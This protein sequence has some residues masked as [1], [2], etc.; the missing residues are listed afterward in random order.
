MSAQKAGVDAIAFS[1]TMVAGI[2]GW[3]TWDMAYGG[4]LLYRKTRPF[5]I[6]LILGTCIGIG[7]AS[8]VYSFYYI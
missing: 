4:V 3:A 2:V 5:F 8:L 1:F 7:G 6:G